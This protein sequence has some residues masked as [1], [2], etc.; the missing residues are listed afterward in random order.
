MHSN[1][2]QKQNYP[3]PIQIDKIFTMRLGEAMTYEVETLFLFQSVNSDIFLALGWRDERLSFDHTQDIQF[4]GDACDQV[5]QPD[6]YFLNGRSGKRHS[7]TK[8]NKA[9]F[10]Y[11]GGHIQLG[12]RYRILT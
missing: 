5:W 7:L 10:V 2:Y 11:R 12:Q 6:I 3:V 4:T 8:Q 1:L 9:L